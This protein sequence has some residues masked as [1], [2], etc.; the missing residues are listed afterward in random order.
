[1]VT[2]LSTR[3]PIARKSHQC[4]SCLGTIS[5]GD[6]YRKQRIVDGREAWTWKAHTL[7]DAIMARL[8]LELK[9]YDDESPDMHE[10]FLPRLQDVFAGLVRTT[11]GSGMRTSS[12][13]V[14]VL[15]P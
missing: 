12:P 9:L 2:L 7:C 13:S 4:G 15:G 6:R 1:M 10:D 8:F 3:S 5:P 14:T 11:T